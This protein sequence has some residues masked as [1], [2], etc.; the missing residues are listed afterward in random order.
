[1]CVRSIDSATGGGFN[2]RGA[3]GG[4][5]AVRNFFSGWLLAALLLSG[6]VGA[7]ISRAQ[8]E[9]TDEEIRAARRDQNPSDAQAR[10]AEELRRAADA[11]ERT[12]RIERA[13]RMAPIDLWFGIR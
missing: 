7:A 13:R 9:V 4:A 8:P 6:S 1:L 11:A 2:R 5:G 3:A 10:A 12:M